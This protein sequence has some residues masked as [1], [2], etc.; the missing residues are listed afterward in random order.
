MDLIVLGVKR[1]PVQLEAS[2]H[3]PFGTAYTV[4]SLA[5]CPVL[6]VRG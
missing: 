2:A 4:V 6:T 5:A 1:A 3:L